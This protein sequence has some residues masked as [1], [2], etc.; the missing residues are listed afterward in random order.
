MAYVSE[1]LKVIAEMTGLTAGATVTMKDFRELAGWT[2]KKHD[3]RNG[4]EIAADIIKRAGL[5]FKK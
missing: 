4:D 1:A 5:R 2:D 3:D